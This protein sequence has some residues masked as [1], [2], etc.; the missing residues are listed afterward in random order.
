MSKK[1]V[2]IVVLIAVPLLIVFLLISLLL[3]FYAIPYVKGND[4]IQYVNKNAALAEEDTWISVDN[5]KFLRIVEEDDIREDTMITIRA[6]PR[7]NLLSWNKLCI[8]YRIT[9]TITDWDTLEEI[10]KIQQ[11]RTVVFTFL[12]FKWVVESVT[13]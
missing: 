10:K 12:D 5:L 2:P 11:E 9:A 1:R 6:K 8:R 4:C 3:C 13:A 7:F